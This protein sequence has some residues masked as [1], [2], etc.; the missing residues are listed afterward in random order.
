MFCTNCGKKLEQS[1]K[2]CHQC[3]FEKVTEMEKNQGDGDKK[4][5]S[6]QREDNQDMNQEKKALEDFQKS[7]VHSFLAS[8]DES[9]ASDKTQK[10]T[11]KMPRPSLEGKKLQNSLFEEKRR[12]PLKTQQ[13]FGM[14]FFMMI[15]V[16][17]F[18]ILLHWSFGNS[19]N[20]NKQS[21]ARATILFAL[22][23]LGMWI[24][25]SFV[26]QSLL[27][28]IIENLDVLEGM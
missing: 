22:F 14:F 8:S 16:V 6:N 1:F 23:I 26:F 5:Q 10:E 20:I 21:F 13:Y 3:G 25:L 18:I 24:V 2:F 17:N 28:V 12:N 7:S 4:N 27:F 19:V 15:P 9:T 11:V